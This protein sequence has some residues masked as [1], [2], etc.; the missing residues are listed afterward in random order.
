MRRPARWTSLRP[1]GWHPRNGLPVNFRIACFWMW[2]ALQPIFCLFLMDRLSVVGRTDPARLASGE[3]V[4]TGVLRTNLAAIVQS[5]PVAGR[6]CRV[7]SEYFAISGDVHLILGHL[8]PEDYTCSTPDGRPPSVDSARRRL[9]RLVCAD[10]EMLSTAEIDEMAEYIYE[11]QIRQIRE[12]LSQVLSRLPR[13][14]KHPVIVVGA[15]AFLGLAAAKS[16]DLEILRFV[17]QM[18]T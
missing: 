6:N 16:L 11:Q 18:G 13:L 3:L 1:I 14:R 5:V 7:A 15:G 17:R 12:G 8:R 10:I 2:A 9:A 4:F